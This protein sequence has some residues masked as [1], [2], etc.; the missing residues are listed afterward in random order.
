MY[1]MYNV[2]A[3]LKTGHFVTA[4]S[5]EQ[6]ILCS[7]GTDRTPIDGEWVRCPVSRRTG[8]LKIIYHPKHHLKNQHVDLNKDQILKALRPLRF[9]KAMKL[10]KVLRAS[11]K[12]VM[13]TTLDLVYEE[14]PPPLEE[15]LPVT[16]R[17]PNCKSIQQKVKNLRKVNRLLRM[18][19]SQHQKVQTFGTIKY[20][21]AY[22][23]HLY[24]SV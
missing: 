1:T 14:V 21:E 9:K 15:E 3:H 6:Q 20:R 16:C 23:N 24:Y 12:E 19:L 22:C 8:C 13:S 18:Q 11:K 2:D 17:N 5:E 7:L 10:L 4:S